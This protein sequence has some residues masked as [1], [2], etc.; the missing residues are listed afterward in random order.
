MVEIATRTYRHLISGSTYI[1]KSGKIA[2]FYGK[3]GMPGFYTTNQPSE[4]EELDFLAKHPQVQVELVESVEDTI[5]HKPAD[6]TIARAVMEVQ[7][8]SVRSNSPEVIAATDNLAK[9]IA[10]AKGQP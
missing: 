4:I 8:A 3:V 5:S 1:F 2:R 7:E 9:A 6:P 10:A